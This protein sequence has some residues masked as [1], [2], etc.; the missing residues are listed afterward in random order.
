VVASTCAQVMGSAVQ[1]KSC[2]LGI[3]HFIDGSV[4]VFVEAGSFSESMI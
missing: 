2:S 4:V 1:L 3:Y